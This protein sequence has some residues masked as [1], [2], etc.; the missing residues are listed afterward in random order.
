MT[1]QESDAA[2]LSLLAEK[3]R[4]QDL[5]AAATKDYF[6]KISSPGLKERFDQTVE[7]QRLILKNEKQIEKL[8]NP[9]IIFD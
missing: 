5:L 2:L 6:Q 4:L 8:Q 9:H 7:I 1:Q 3:E